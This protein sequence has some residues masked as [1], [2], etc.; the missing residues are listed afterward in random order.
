M[1][2]LRALFLPETILVPNTVFQELFFFDKF[3]HYQPCEEDAT[4]AA[5]VQHDLCEGYAPVPFHDELQR[6]TQLIREL[7]GNEGEFYSGHIS[8]LSSQFPANRDE[9]SVR[10]LITAISGR[11]AKKETAADRKKKEELWQ[12]RL[13]LKLSEI[14][15][16]EEQ[17]LAQALTAV[18]CRE[19][20]LF[21][22]LKGEDEE[23]PFALTPLLPPA[24]SPIKPELILKAWAKL[25]L[26]DSRREKHTILACS[27]EETAELL[28]DVN[29]SFN[30][31]RPV[32]L[33]R[34]PLPILEEMPL[35]EYQDVRRAFRREAQSVIDG[36]H[37]LLAAT[38]AKG[39]ESDTLQNFAG[40]AADWTRTL[41]TFRFGQPASDVPGNPEP[42]RPQ[43]HL[44][45]SLCNQ[46]ASALMQQFLRRTGAAEEA[47]NHALIAV[48]SL[49][50]STCKG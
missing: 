50:K 27:R 38:G 15:Y 23:I 16:K 39:I 5:E 48:K 11:D 14:L 13:L 20:E 12:A 3:Y 32:R 4:A 45:I 41:S 46:S 30:K 2:S 40:L 28:F 29:E 24:T 9:G 10:S 33:L 47:K 18:S 1:T 26:A 19:K 25:F 35:D 8:T 34:I 17:E 31:Q 43:P 36:L 6:F 49:R 42:C 21:E 37:A 7:K 22:A 44:E